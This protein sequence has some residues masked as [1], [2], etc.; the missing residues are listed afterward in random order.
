MSHCRLP[1]YKEMERRRTRRKKDGKE[2]VREIK[3]YGTIGSLDLPVP[4]QPSITDIVNSLH[5]A[6]MP[7]KYLGVIGYQIKRR[8]EQPDKQIPFSIIHNTTLSKYFITMDEFRVIWVRA[9]PRQ[10][11]HRHYKIKYKSKISRNK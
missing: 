2:E 11:W 8:L 5:L 4:L 6:G 3:Y 1:Y 10:Q 9:C 7:V